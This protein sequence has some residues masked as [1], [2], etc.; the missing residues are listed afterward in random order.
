MHD[1]RPARTLAALLV[2]PLACMVAACSTA[3]EPAS[4]RP[5]PTIIDGVSGSCDDKAAAAFVGQTIS[6]DVS[7]KAKAAAGAQGVR[8]IRPGMAVTMDYRAGR[9]NLHLDDAGRI[10]RVTCG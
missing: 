9:L 4:D 8:V 7:A 5:P 10:T 6:E 2:A 3:R 1:H